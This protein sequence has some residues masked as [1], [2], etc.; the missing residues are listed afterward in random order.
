[1]PEPPPSAVIWEAGEPPRSR[2]HGDVY[3]S[4]DD[5]LAESR[6]VFL[7]GCGLPEAW[8]DRRRFTVA[9]LGFGTGLN[10]AALLELWGRARPA[11]GRLNIFT[12]EAE[13][14]SGAEAARAL[15]AWPDL[16]PIAGAMTARWPG[17]ARGFHRVDLPEWGATIDVAI[18][19][20]AEALEAWSGQADAWFLDG[21]APS[22]NPDIWR[23]EVIDLIAR[24]SAP[25]ARVATYT[26]AGAVRRALTATGF[27]VE[28]R[29]GH[30]RKRERLEARRPGVGGDPA[31]MRVA[32][33]G[34]GIAGASLAR[35][36]ADHGVQARL[37]E[38]VQAGAG[39]SGGPA[40][41]A[42][43]RLDAGL[44]PGAALF[45]QAARRAVALYGAIP[46]A[47]IGRGVLQAAI[48]AKDPGRFEAIAAS[49][50]FEAGSMRKLEAAEAARRLGE[51]PRQGEAG[52]LMIEAAVVVD[53]MAVLA[54]WLGGTRIAR[55][56][57]LARGDGRWRL[58]DAAGETLD[59]ADAVCLAAG[60]G[61]AALTPGLAMTPVRGQATW[62]EATRW[63]QPVMFGA[64]ALPT[65]HGVLVGAT[66]DRD[67][68]RPDARAGDR[69]RNL[70]A[71]AES[72]PALAD[73]LA[74]AGPRDWA[75]IRASTRDYLPLAGPAPDAEPGLA[76]L[77]GL[78]SRGFC[79]APLLA[80]HLAAE[81]L[82]AP[83]P[84]P[85]ALAALVDP[86][87]F[88]R[89]AARSARPPRGAPPR[90]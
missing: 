31:A 6:A 48:T 35:A 82:G 83:S 26:V 32:I 13:P 9:E 68:P 8:A 54:A 88:A 17:R 50:L 21:F 25:G 14:L 89:R 19:E 5:G 16:A 62:S 30:G 28:R 42:A 1:M 27:A 55:V 29:P 58:L 77:T 3:F 40:A 38:A 37:F 84:L 56:A 79:L 45:A 7:A 67:D 75:A 49:D 33:V 65:R 46:D 76:L 51:T 60:M 22:L 12:I 71:L 39:A 73:R 52:F 2:R 15:A 47:V 11:G 53:P 24:R 36:F 18:L 61:S 63:T 87:R 57:A 70:A 44:G 23:A 74:A 90:S 59:E 80:E 4:R 86:R 34:A 20:A 81:I 66:H 64:Y 69:V 43:P 72:L 85:R 10:I 78:G 41:L